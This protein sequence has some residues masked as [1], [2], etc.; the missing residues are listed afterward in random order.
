[1]PPIDWNAKFPDLRPIRSAPGLWNVNGCGLFF[2][3]HRD[4]DAETGSSVRTRC[5]HILGIP[6]LA[7]G[8][9][10][11]VEADQEHTILG[12]EPL[13]PLARAF[14]ASVIFAVLW[15][16]GYYG[17]TKY[18]G[19]PE[20]MARQQLR[21]ADVLAAA[22]RS[23]EAAR[24]CGEVV[25][26]PGAAALADQ[27]ARRVE[28]LV[29]QSA[30]RDSAA[31]SAGVLEVAV[32]LGQAGRWPEPPEAL[33]RRGR[34]LIDRHAAMDPAG[35]LAI[36]EAVAPLAPGGEDLDAVRRS[37][38]EPLVAAHPDD[39]QL[40]SR[41]A[42]VY[43]VRG[44]D[45]RGAALL[46]PLRDRLG[47]TE[48]AR[49]LG[50]ADA[51]RGRVEQALALLRPYT[52]ARLE[53]LRTATEAL[54]AARQALQRRVLDQ[55]KSGRAGDLDLAHFLEATEAEQTAQLSRFFSDQ[56]RRDQAIVAAQGRM[57]R[58]SSAVPVAL[59][60]GLI[61]M[62]HA[63]GLTDPKARQEELNEAE[64]I[65]LA[66]GRL[67]EGADAP[68]LSLAQVY[69][70][71]GKQREGRALFED[72]LKARR[73]DPRLLVEVGE[74]LRKVG[75]HSEA[76]ALAEEAYQAARDP[77]V[78]EQAA[79]ERGLLGLDADD[80]VL[81]LRRGNPTH[82]EVKALLSS[83][84][85]HQAMNR[86]D[87]AAAIAHLR[88]AIGLYETMPEN[89]PTL[90]N[91]AMALLHLG[92]L[93]GEAAVFVRGLAKVE[94]A[95]KLEPSDSLTMMNAGHFLLEEALRD[96][97]GP[98]IDLGLL[99]EGGDI[100]T[101]DFL[102]RDAAGRAETVRRLR[103]HPG[104]NR[105]IALLD[106]ALLLS[107]RLGGLY[108]VLNQV[109][110]RR[111]EVA[112][113]RD[114]LHRLGRADLDQSGEIALAREYFAGRRDGELRARA[115]AAIARAESALKAARARKGDLTFA[116]AAG[117]L[118]KARIGGAHLGL[119]GEADALV[120]LAEEALAAAPS[121]ET[122]HLLASALL[123]RAGRR[124]GRS[125]PAYAKM[126]E[127]TRRS[128]ADTYLIGVALGGDDPLRDEARRDSDVRR[129]VDLV[130]E[131]YRA[132][133]RSEGGA[134][135]WALLR[136][137]DPSAA[138]DVARTFLHDES[139]RLDLAIRR[140]VEPTSAMVALACSWAAEM[141]GKAA[142]GRAILKEFAARGVP[143]PIDPP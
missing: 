138:A 46:E 89:S 3:G 40:A 86:G 110:G 45:E 91:A 84:L 39:P 114:L 2:S 41:L 115:T 100:D 23:A 7:L 35:A 105:A 118:V 68:R 99:R 65:F 108:K 140:R 134:W 93:T 62:Q 130:L 95:H 59:E 83:D 123:F 10:R 27:A 4:Y 128:L 54:A 142:E 6:V 71:Q 61:L 98:S 11:V 79:I 97:I 19:T 113:Q 34:A 88:E 137:T 104:L 37:L 92:T 90:N 33:Y 36:L 77:R 143:L 85:A 69:Y 51:R 28:T 109:Y 53:A 32:A 75:S 42:A 117:G 8:A 139:G 24:L 125:Q 124:L 121:H 96:I 119:G 64:N 82:P 52:R 141:E 66:V 63:Q 127:K 126:A 101:L 43:E 9:Y 58:E 78:K 135:T 12:R 107:P 50:M 74:L 57:L 131:A 14:N 80:K 47:L 76:R 55:L 20:Y 102:D 26:G 48:G 136:A 129:A 111:E 87:E 13:S 60:L 106:K 122:R 16:G 17:W 30:A 133:P 94:K 103:S 49:I 22:G 1:M 31:D 15:L 29:E 116:V 70:W 21:L 73:R 81:W 72:V 132:D 18:T 5:L 120:A 38:L 25:R 56:L 112:K 44:Q 67:T